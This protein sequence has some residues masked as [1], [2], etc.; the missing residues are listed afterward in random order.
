M[1]PGL[2]FSN[3]E[4][5]NEWKAGFPIWKLKGKGKKDGK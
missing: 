3:E 4:H 1:K 5:G 2:E